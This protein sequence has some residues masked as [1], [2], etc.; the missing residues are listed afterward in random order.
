MNCATIRERIPL[1]L[2]G[3]LSADEEARIEE[4]LAVCADCRRRLEQEKL[5]HRALDLA[6]TA[7]P[8]ELL[9]ECRR[10]LP[11]ALGRRR[12]LAGLRALAGLPARLASL[13]PRPARAAALIALGFL[14][15]RFTSGPPIA[16]APS[17]GA[18][19]RVRSAQ[20]GPSGEIRLV[21]EETRPK[22]VQ[23]AP[24][25]AAIRRLLIGAV[26]DPVD[27]AVRA[28]AIEMLGRAP[29]SPEIRDALLDALEHDPNPG[30]RLRALE[31][32]K[33]YAD[34]AESRQALSRVLLADG[35]PGV[36][37]LAVD[38]LASSRDPDVVEVLQELMAREN[39]AYVRTRSQRALQAMNASLGIF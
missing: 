4:H 38:L 7:P 10:S 9:A 26:R 30:V 20:T 25:D 3:E 32:L 13:V 33:P 24:G 19:L 1:Y 8:P 23:G 12:P 27:P 6:G 37:T 2:Y 16:M 21:V 28:D 11:A 15:A 17:E 22:I 31:G 39:D 29:R 14:G 36:R 18:A 5:F 35:D 34:E